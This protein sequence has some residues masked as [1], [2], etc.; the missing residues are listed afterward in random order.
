MGAKYTHT[1]NDINE[2]EHVI[3]L[4]ERGV[5]HTPTTINCASPGYELEWQGNGSELYENK[6]YSSRVSIPFIIENSTDETFFTTTLATS[7]E[8]TFD[9]TITK[10]GSLLWVGTILS[11]QI[12]FDRQSI[13]SKLII[14]LSAVDGLSRL[15]NYDFDFATQS[16][17]QKTGTDLI[18]EILNV[19]GLSDYFGSGTYFSDGMIFNNANK[20]SG[21]GYEYIKLN[22]LQFRKGDVFKMGDDIEPMNCKEALETLLSGFAAQIFMVDGRYLIRQILPYVNTNVS[23]LN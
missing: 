3:S 16:T 22:K 14:Q 20:S 19:N 17:F 21:A 15:E 18:T 8:E 4:F 12:N 23:F 9:I 1:F 5:S 10:G 11:D 6:I 7:P 2:V 13:E